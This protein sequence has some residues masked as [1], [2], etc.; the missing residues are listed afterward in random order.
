V[1]ITERKYQRREYYFTVMLERAFAVS[2]KKMFIK[3]HVKYP[4]FL[5]GPVIIASTQGG[6]N[7][8]EVAEENPEAII[9]EPVDI[10]KGLTREQ[11]L[12]LADKLGLTV[13]REEAA[14]MFQKLYNV[15]I[16][17][18]AT[19]IEINPLAEDSSGTCKHQ[20]HNGRERFIHEILFTVMCLD[21]KMRFD[22][23]A[24]FRQSKVFSY[25]DWSQENEKEVEAAHFNLNFIA[26][27]GDIGCLVNGA[28]LAMATMDIIKLHGG[29]PANFLDVGGGATAAQVKEA[30]KIITSDTKVNA[31]LVNI[32]G[33]IMRCDVIAEGIII[34]ANE[35]N[36]KTPIV[37]R[38]QVLELC[39]SFFVVLFIISIKFDLFRAPMSM[40]PRC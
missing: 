35:L 40:M 26:L 5:Q 6:M 15:F 36:L 3:F 14:D 4:I 38:L 17:H 19:M 33:G 27:D 39:H 29:E 28:G 22:D 31:I 9:K 23:N 21:A 24:D 30:F 2:S 20:L 1:M 34:A 12:G 11:A 18:D 37:C 8:E 7:I 16:K 10:V 25:R 32:F 13:K